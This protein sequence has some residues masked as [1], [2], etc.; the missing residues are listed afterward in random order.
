MAKKAPKSSA[1]KKTS[2]GGRKFSMVGLHA[3][4]DATLDRLKTES[5]TKKRDELIAL[6]QGLRDDTR[7]PQ[8]MLIDL[9]V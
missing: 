6:V 2:T 5:R 7:C 4:L 1:K 8:D 3:K 9:G